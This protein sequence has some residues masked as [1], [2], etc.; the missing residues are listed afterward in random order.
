MLTVHQAR[1][2][3]MIKRKILEKVASLSTWP[4]LHEDD[5]NRSSGSG[6]LIVTSNSDADSSGS[7]KVVADSVD[8]D[9]ELVNVSKQPVDNSNTSTP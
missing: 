7:T 1:S 5:E 2:E 6:S 8:G 9:E 4:D 3:D